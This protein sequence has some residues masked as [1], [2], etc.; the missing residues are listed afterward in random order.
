MVEAGGDDT[1]RRVRVQYSGRVQ[2]VGFR[3][4]TLE[5]AR[6]LDVSGFV[7]NLPDGTVELEAQGAP[8]EVERL[9]ERVAARFGRQIREAR[10]TDAPLVGGD[11]P[12]EIRF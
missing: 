1:V 11:D 6:G 9:L 3:Y 8:A 5:I 2:G 12:F 10:R 7:R 4:T